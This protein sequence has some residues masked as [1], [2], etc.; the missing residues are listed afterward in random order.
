M[1]VIY[2]G[3]LIARTA[4]S[5]EIIITEWPMHNTQYIYEGTVND[6]IKNRSFRFFQSLEY[7]RVEHIDMINGKLVFGL[8]DLREY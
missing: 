5:K 7:R 1:S 6:M 2:L 8:T 3:D 4:G